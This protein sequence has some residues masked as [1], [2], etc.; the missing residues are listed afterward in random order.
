MGRYNNYKLFITNKN[1]EIKSFG[2]HHL[3]YSGADLNGYSYVYNN[4]S[5][6]ITENYRDTI[7]QYDYKNKILRAEYYMDYKD[8]K[9]PNRYLTGSKENFD[10]AINNN[11][12][13]FYIGK[14]LKAGTHSLFVLRNSYKGNRAVVYRD[15]VTGHLKGGTIMNFDTGEIPA[16]SIPL[17]SYG[18]YFVSIHNANAYDSL[19]VHSTI[20]SDSDKE[21]ILNMKS[22]D[23]PALIFYQ[24]K[25]F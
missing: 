7:Y 4:N 16:F 19:L 18:D 15:N 22:D 14:F 20:L 24:L 25:D 9:L 6:E 10:N 21:K 17:T 3:E 1:F 12:Y 11:D 13:Y 8:K 2:L 23:N 5:I